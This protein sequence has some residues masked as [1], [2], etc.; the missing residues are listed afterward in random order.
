PTE[1]PTLSL[2]DALPIC[3]QPALPPHHR[4]GPARHAPGRE[5]RGERN[6]GPQGVDR[7]WGG[8]ACRHGPDRTDPWPPTSDL[9]GPLGLRAARSEEHTS[10]LQSLRHLV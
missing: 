6:R 1:L 8:L 7:E 3:P 4:P 9:R 2:P 5:A 10:E